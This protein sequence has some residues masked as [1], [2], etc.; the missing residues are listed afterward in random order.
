MTPRDVRQPLGL[1]RSAIAVLVLLAVG[2]IL[3]SFYAGHRET[4]QYEA[5]EKLRVD[6]AVDAHFSAVRDHLSA[7]ENLAATVSTLFDPPP[8]PASNP[9]GNF[10][11]HVIA[12]AP[13]IST[14]GWLPEVTADNAA[15]ALQ[16]MAASGI[17]DPRFVG[18]D[19]API[20]P[21][22]LGRP[23]YPIIDIAPESNRRLLGVD[24]GSFP[25][26]LDAIRR[27][28]D[29]RAVSR[30]T[31]LRLVQA[32]ESEAILLYAPVYAKDGRFLG[33]MG[34][35]YKVERLFQ[36]ALA[37]AQAAGHFG[38]RVMSRN[39]DVPLF[40][41]GP[42]Q[43]PAAA[44][45][46]EARTT[47]KIE[48]KTDFGGRELR[49]VYAAPSNPG[50]EGFWRG[51]GVTL[52]GLGLTVAA[53]SLLGFMANRTS[54]LTREVSS[55]RSA[56]DRLK[57]LIHELNH[58]V[59]NVMSVAQA[60]VRLSFTP[61]ASLPDVQKTCEGRLQALANA[62]SLLTASDWKNISI[63]SLITEEILPFSERIR[64]SGPDLALSGRSAQT[65]ALLLHE[66]ATNAVKH[67]AL[68]VP[69]GQVFLTW[70]IE[71][72]E[73]EAT[74]RLRWRETGGPEARQPTHRGFGE[75][76]V[77]RIAPR[78]LAGRGTATY[79]TDGFRYELEAPLREVTSPAV[80]VAAE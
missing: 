49:F 26:R 4:R 48:R 8:L 45:P 64:T 34:F 28:R 12:L 1:P 11:E 25:E 74:F 42:G 10:G 6:E 19:G 71:Q 77:K 59:R 27:A 21:D 3:L 36:A 9:L 62:M 55:R 30:T 79:E 60:I 2:G 73:P 76:L 67:G 32:P 23:L 53:V 51:L 15:A 52:A 68:S 75:L 80:Q 63:R 65:F 61:G 66:L 72:A 78:D 31:P 57:V 5:L 44:A 13:E 24:A 69:R 50:N 43:G 18:A 46:D 7:R 17:S 39:V 56:E 16:S 41:A 35:A 37:S 58:R 29:S 20:S 14:V 33:V 70:Q 54:A 22:G 40:A 47:T 38:V